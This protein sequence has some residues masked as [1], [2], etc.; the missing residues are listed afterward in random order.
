[1]TLYTKNITDANYYQPLF[2]VLLLI[3]EALYLVKFPHLHLAY[4]ANKFKEITIPAYVEAFLNII[5]SVLLVRKL[6]LVG[7]AIGTIAGMTYRMVFHVYYTSK[8]IPGRKQ[9]IFYKKFFLFSVTAI[10]G[11]FVCHRFVPL[12]EVTVGNWILYAVIYSLILGVLY[13]G[14]SLIFFKKELKFFL[15][16][17]KK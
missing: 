2:G 17:L 3:S 16:Y 6:G 12:A 5:I 15:R 8:I 13:G 11:Y 7:V 9:I 4:S 1:M 10:L 14:I